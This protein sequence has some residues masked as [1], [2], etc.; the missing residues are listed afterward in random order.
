LSINKEVEE[1][2][3]KLHKK[4]ERLEKLEIIHAVN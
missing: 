3:K 2:D 1:F 4:A